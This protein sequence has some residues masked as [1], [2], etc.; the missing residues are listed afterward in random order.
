[1]LAIYRCQD[2]KQ[3]A[4]QMAASRAAAL[5][6]Q[7]LKPTAADTAAIKKEMTTIVQDALSESLHLYVFSLLLCHNHPHYLPVCV[8]RRKCRRVLR[9]IFLTLQFLVPCGCICSTI[10]VTG[11]AVSGEDLHKCQD[12]AHRC[13]SC[14]SSIAVAFFVALVF[15][16]PLLLL[17]VP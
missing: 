15:L 1:M 7:Y 13:V 10:P 17:P 8:A 2:L 12:G 11:H 3:Q 5:Q 4:L 6:Q 16:L 14:C 9:P